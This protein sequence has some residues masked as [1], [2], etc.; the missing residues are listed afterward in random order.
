MTTEEK[1][2]KIML[3]KGGLIATINKELL[4]CMIESYNLAI[5]D[6]VKVAKIGQTSRFQA[7]AGYSRRVT[8]SIVD[9][10]SILKL[11]LKI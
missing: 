6:A 3:E 11:K 2:T 7:A 1:L 9:K 5:E 10:K 4:S 8:K